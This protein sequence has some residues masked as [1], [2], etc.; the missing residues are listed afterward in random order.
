[1]SRRKKLKVIIP[2]VVV[3]FLAAYAKHRFI[4]GKYVVTGHLS[5]KTNEISG[6]AASA[7]NKDVFYVMNDSGD[8]SRFFAIN[9]KGLILST[10][11]YPWDTHAEQHDC[12]DIATGPGP[13]TGKSYVYIANIGDNRSE[14]KFVSI[15]RVQDSPAF[16]TKKQ[17]DVKA[18]VVNLKYPDS[19]K[20][21]EAF[22]ID[23]L[24]K[25]MYIVTKRRDSVTVYTAPLSFKP[26]DTLTLKKRCSLFFQGMKP[27]KWITAGSISHDG[28]HILL[29]S[30]QKVYYWHRR[31]GEAVW[32]ALK[33]KP[34]AEP[35]Y[36][37]EKF[38]E[39]I[40]F[41]HDGKGYYT[42]SEGVYSNIYYYK[43]P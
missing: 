38:G 15:Y 34:D 25:L 43:T 41:T 16:V 23:P 4:D 3:L 35:P 22:M 13:V 12:E 26:N 32:Q 17:V 29:K 5:K 27:F 33:R 9:P 10:I 30:Y 7:I 8:K 18:T 20:D 1:M 42:T 40:G 21:A 28:Q 37:Q 19:P 6:I 2:L 24:D 36:K 11:S 14:R 31:E 39:A